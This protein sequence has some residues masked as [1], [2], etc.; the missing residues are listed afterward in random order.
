MRSSMIAGAVFATLVMVPAAAA[1]AASAP[2]GNDVS[3]PQCGQALPS[4]QAF[5]IVAVNE[6]VANTTNSCLAAEIAW[7][8]A[9]SA[10]TPQPR[11]PLAPPDEAPPQPMSPPRP[12][13]PKN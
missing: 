4:G 3:Y 1:S 9:T 10:A 12:H 8:Q 13:K 6:G 7:A 2:T 5:G 11:A